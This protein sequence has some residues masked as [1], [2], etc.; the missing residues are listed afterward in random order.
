M[1]SE[2]SGLQPQ[3]VVRGQRKLRAGWTDLKAG[4]GSLALGRYLQGG[5]APPPS[6]PGFHQLLLLR[7]L[8]GRVQPTTPPP[9]PGVGEPGR[10]HPKTL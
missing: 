8:P 9:L 6:P 5:S 1:I 2:G 3:K 10:L 4:G 7:P